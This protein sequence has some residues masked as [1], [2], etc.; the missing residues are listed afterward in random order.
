MGT[1]IIPNNHVANRAYQLWEQAGRPHGRDLEFWIQA[2]AEVHAAP[3]PGKTALASAAAS[4]PLQAAQPTRSLATPG[5][6]SRAETRPPAK[7]P[8]RRTASRVR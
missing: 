1:E 2:E 8:P 5:G 4:Q 7:K 3:A 6:E